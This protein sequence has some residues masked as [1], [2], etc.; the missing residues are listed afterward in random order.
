LSIAVK[1]AR[2][3]VLKRAHMVTRSEGGKGA[4]REVVE[5]I[6]KAQGK[7]SKLIAPMLL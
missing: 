3:E 6:L 1:N 4:V 2:P 7:W 5:F